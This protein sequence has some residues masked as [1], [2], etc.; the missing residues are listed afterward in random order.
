MR[1]L[2]SILLVAVMV[3]GVG[4]AAF[5]GS[6]QEV[7]NKPVTITYMNFIGKEKDQVGCT[8]DA[9]QKKHPNVKFDYQITP[10]DTLQQKLPVMIAANNVV[11]FF[12]WNAMPLANAFAKNPEAF[13]D[14]TPYFDQDKAFASRFIDGTWN[15]L[16]TK[17]GKIPGFPAE[18]QV[19]AWMWNKA[20]FDKYGLKIP[21]TDAELLAC[22]PVFKKNGIA[23][24]V[25]GDLDPWPTWGYVQW[26]QLWGSDEWVPDML[27]THKTKMVDSGYKDAFNFIA[28][29]AEAGAF[30]ANNSTINFEA[31]VQMFLAGKGA[32]I[33]L[34]T[35]Q[36]GKLIG[37]PIEKDLVYNWG[38]TF[39]KSKY[40]QNIAIKMVGNAYGVGSG[41]A[42]DKDKLNALIAF[43]KWRY[44]DEGFPIA[45]N[46]GFVLPVK[47]KYDPA[48][49]SP[50]NKQQIAMINDSRKGTV[51]EI[52][53][54]I[55][56]Y[57]W[58][59]PAYTLAYQEPGRLVNG[60]IDGS[61]KKSDIVPLLQ[62]GD[63]GIDK[64]I[65]Y[66]KEKKLW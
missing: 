46:A 27:K 15:L 18:M 62:K 57:L 64:A 58:E 31:M 6:D 61:L 9:Y 40:N 37:S 21:T 41:V 53:A 54:V 11:D 49:L 50:I 59:W 52:Y 38:I 33:S 19:Q 32:G 48:S 36:L 25:Y 42:K 44:S 26:F 8:I 17:D 2:F 13:V 1:K 7:T 43:N 56:T 51:T 22:V 5:A 16:K 34:P 30:P 55:N 3:L 20:L 35:D 65:A 23:T 28:D 47:G 12:W 39:P 60:L 63:E 66:M 45:L 14:L 4:A 10:H 29:L 24:I